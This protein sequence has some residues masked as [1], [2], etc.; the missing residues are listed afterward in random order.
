MTEYDSEDESELR[1][2]HDDS[3]S[4]VEDPTFEPFHHAND[5]TGTGDTSSSDDSDTDTGSSE[6]WSSSDTTTGSELSNTSLEGSFSKV[7][8]VHKG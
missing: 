6:F 4:E 7:N 8:V 2:P 5:N 1:P 3:E